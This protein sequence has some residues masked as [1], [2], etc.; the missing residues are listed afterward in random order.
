MEK[1]DDAKSIETMLHSKFV[2]CPL[3]YAHSFEG[4]TELRI[5]TGEEVEDIIRIVNE[6]K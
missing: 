3:H 2:N 5:L 4:Y 1:V 6:A